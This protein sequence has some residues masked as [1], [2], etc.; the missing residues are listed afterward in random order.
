MQYT[1]L[2]AV[3]L[4]VGFPGNST[5]KNMDDVVVRVQ[6]VCGWNL[7]LNATRRDLMALCKT[8]VKSEHLRARRRTCMR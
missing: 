2:S 7:K 1:N 8:V 6:R 5:S 3:F 4:E